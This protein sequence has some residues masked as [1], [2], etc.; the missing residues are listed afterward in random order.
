VPLLPGLLSNKRKW[1]KILTPIIEERKKLIQEGVEERMDVLSWLID[2]AKGSE[3]ASENLAFRVL[4]INHGA[5][6]TTTLIIVHILYHLA[7]E[8]HYLPPLRQ[9][10]EEAIAEEGWTKNAMDRMHK[11]DSF[12]KETMRMRTI[13]T[14]LVGHKA[15]QDHTFNDGT[16]IPRGTVLVA[17]ASA[18]HY[19]EAN[20]SNAH[21]FQ[22][23]RFIDQ[24]GDADESSRRSFVSLTSEYFPF[25]HGNHACPGRFFAASSM[26]LVLSHLLINYDFMLE[27]GAN[28]GGGKRPEDF[29][30]GGIRIPNQQ[31]RLLFRKRQI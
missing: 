15:L 11:L 4:L 19:D 1:L 7:S 18:V 14:G 22:G 17:P 26:K 16:F 6:S 28:A 9:E 8:L 13:S 30:I 27:K 3:I 10:I 2:E 29:F 12:I 25:G 20:Y 5:F 21:E 31:A 23:F 24:K